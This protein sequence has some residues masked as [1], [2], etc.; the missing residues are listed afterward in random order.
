MDTIKLLVMFLLGLAFDFFI[1]LLLLRFLMQKL[2][3]NFY[4]PI[5]R[6]VLKITRFVKPLQKI[7]PLY[8]G[9][10]FGLLILVFLIEIIKILLLFW[11]QFGHLPVI[12]GV[13]P[14]A[15]GEILNRIIDIFFY[16]L[17]IRVILSWVNPDF[18]NP[19]YEITYLLT[20][21][22]LR[23]VR[24]FIPTLGGFD[25]S[26]LIVAFALKAVAII[27]IVPLIQWGQI[28]ATQGFF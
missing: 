15:M 8:R 25:F 26:P 28:I 18:R 22:L 1:L 3:V 16:A 17:L 14:W 5:F 21:F 12:V 6:F 20:E 11:L 9:F 27:A 13:F 2:R 7:I 19:A 24:R 4:N 23:P 10:D